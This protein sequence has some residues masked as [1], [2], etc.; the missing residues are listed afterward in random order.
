MVMRHPVKHSFLT[1]IV[2]GCLVT[3]AAPKAL[4]PAGEE[5]ALR[6]GK[7][8][9]EAT[10]SGKIGGEEIDFARLAKEAREG[11]GRLSSL[12]AGLLFPLARLWSPVLASLSSLLARL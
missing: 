8:G 2:A 11:A 6:A 12:L 4:T 9:G 3:R 1:P 10:A 7:K 5:A